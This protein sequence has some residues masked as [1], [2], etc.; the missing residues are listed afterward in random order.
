MIR[1]SH[2]E[3]SFGGAF[4]FTSSLKAAFADG[5]EQRHLRIIDVDGALLTVQSESDCRH[6]PLF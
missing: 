3:G 2:C 1:S 4:S 6:H 5:V